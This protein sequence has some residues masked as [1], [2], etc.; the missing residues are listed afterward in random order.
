MVNKV[1][2]SGNIPELKAAIASI[3]ALH[4]MIG[5]PVQSTG[6]EKELAPK[7]IGKILIKLCFSGK[8]TKG[9][10]KTVE[11]SFRL[12]GTQDNPQAITLERIKYLSN[13]IVEKFDNWQHQTGRNSFCYADWNLGYQLQILALNQAEAQRLV[14]QILDIQGH[15]PEW[16]YLTWTKNVEE[17]S[18]YAETPEKVQIAGH[19]VRPRQQ[20]PICTVTFQRALIKFP[21]IP[22]AFPLCSKNK[23][24]IENLNFLDQP[25]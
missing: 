1:R 10:A 18:R 22:S 12:M 15:S 17:N 5:D 24:L 20:R 23:N 25:D 8:T 13:R 4:Q 3:M 19:L 9:R 16:E 2:L 14:E 6:F 11:S 7:R 21:H